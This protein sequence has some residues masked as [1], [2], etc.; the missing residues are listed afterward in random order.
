MRK[1]I[2]TQKNGFWKRVFINIPFILLVIIIMACF[3]AGLVLLFYSAVSGV[4]FKSAMIVLIVLGASLI[5]IGSGLGFI[6]VYQKY[7][8]FYNKRM[9]W[10]FEDDKPER[11][12]TYTDRQLTI[13]KIFS[14]SNISLAFLALG[15]VFVII[16]AGLGSINRD[17]WVKSVG[18]FRATR[19]YYSDVRNEPIEFD[20][21]GVTSEQRPIT[22]VAVVYPE[23]KTKKRIIL[24]YVKDPSKAS[25]VKVEGYKKFKDDFT[26]S[27][28]NDG[29][30]TVHIGAP[31]E[32]N[33]TLDRLLFFIYNDY[34]VERQI[35]IY[36][37]YGYKDRVAVPD[38]DEVIYVD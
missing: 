24:A 26:C 18:T 37:P 22:E 5:L 10:R 4:A 35:I 31:P 16:S 23:E 15:A 1:R 17:N 7:Y 12:V 25:Y 6:I 3:A 8:A 9:G 32:H 33:S 19:G 38:A 27:R 2:A 30:I 36:V 11:T 13:K 20:I 34:A 29:K 14:L 21:N 28:S